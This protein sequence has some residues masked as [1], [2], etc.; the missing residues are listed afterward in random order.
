MSI[1][2][3]NFSP[4]SAPP[5]ATHVRIHEPHRHHHRSTAAT[6]ETL[7]VDP[8]VL[9]LVSLMV[10]PLV[11]ILPDGSDNVFGYRVKLPHEAFAP[12]ASTPLR[13]FSNET[14]AKAEALK[15]LAREPKESIERMLKQEAW[16]AKRRAR[17]ESAASLTM[18]MPRPNLKI[19]IPQ[20]D[21]E[22]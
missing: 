21:T 18:D 9:P 22:I 5:S 11:Q 7:P 14:D 15:L 12:N 10:L 1:T 19:R 8:R 20:L 16:D 6:E 4:Y 17:L 2:P 13:L 3:S